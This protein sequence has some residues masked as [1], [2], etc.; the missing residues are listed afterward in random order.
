MIASRRVGA[1]LA[2]YFR[3]VQAARERYRARFATREERGVNLLRE[4]LSPEQRAQFDAKR[5]FDV[6]G[7]DSG[8]RYRIHYG[9]TTNVHE[10]GDDDLPSVGWCFMPVGSL[11]VGDVMLAQKI[12]LETYEYGALAVANRCPIR[13]S[14]FR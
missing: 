11:V 12:A 3:E 4:W 8:K 7:C 9:E 2:Q 1:S 6:I 5:Y 14:R 13:F 10:I